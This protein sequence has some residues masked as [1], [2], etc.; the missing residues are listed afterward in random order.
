MLS[1]DRGGEGDSAV[2]VPGEPQI[3]ILDCVL[4]ASAM[5][6]ESK[7]QFSLTLAVLSSRGAQIKSNQ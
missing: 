6:G 4:A 2:K 1:P 5:I 3:D 7:N